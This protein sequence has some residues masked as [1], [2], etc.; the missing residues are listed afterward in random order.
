MQGSNTG[1]INYIE[2]CMFIAKNI[3]YLFNVQKLAKKTCGL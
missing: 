3:L 1:S 2:S